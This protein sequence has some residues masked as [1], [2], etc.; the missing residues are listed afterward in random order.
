MTT[1]ADLLV[2]RRR[3]RRK[4]TFWRAALILLAIA[5]LLTIGSLVSKDG[6]FGNAGTPHVAKLEIAGMITYDP[7]L[8]SALKRIEDNTAA[9]ALLLH[10]DSPGGSTAG[11]EAIY[12][13]LRRISAKK[14]IVA[15]IGTMGASGAYIAALGADEIIATK[16]SLV[17][18]IG[19]L[20]QWAEVSDL[21]KSWGINFQ[22][23]KTSPLK[24]A[25]NF[26]EPPSEE[27]KAA[28][29]SLVQDSF[30]WFRGLVAERRHFNESQLALVADGRV[31]TGRQSLELKLIDQLG[32]ENT[33]RDWL[34]QNKKISAKLPMRKYEPEEQHLPNWLGLARI[35]AGTLGL[36]TPWVS[37][38]QGA[39]QRLDGL[40]SLWQPS[41]EVSL[42]A[43]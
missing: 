14:P 17:G 2:D 16:T 23:V 38:L 35:M 32:D 19:V 39:T 22:E 25:P 11:S 31:Y 13:A 12:N 20:V 29:A 21:M 40:V 1:D 4:L 37:A 5:A 28:L 36:P 3:L 42:N 24:A 7:K 34:T 33:A 18:S 30:N 10:I 8:L 43:Q 41:G 27:A 26:F 6:A 15:Q 9:K